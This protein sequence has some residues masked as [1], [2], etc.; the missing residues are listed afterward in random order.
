M[1]EEEN[2]GIC[3]PVHSMDGRGWG[4]VCWIN[5]DDPTEGLPIRFPLPR[6]RSV[7]VTMPCLS[8]EATKILTDNGKQDLQQK[9][10]DYHAAVLK[11]RVDFIEYGKPEEL[12]DKRRAKLNCGLLKQV[13]IHRADKLIT[14]TGQMLPTKISTVWPS[15]Q[16]DT[17]K[18][19]PCW[20]TLP[21][22]YQRCR[23]ATSI[24]RGSS[25]T[26]RTA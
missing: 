24:S 26:S 14:A 7:E 22:D 25:W 8:E 9:L 12:S 10:E 4:A 20:A 23:R 17:S 13:L 19:L 18:P 5:G 11:E 3:A 15:P 2:R 16:G 1:T 6:M 21:S